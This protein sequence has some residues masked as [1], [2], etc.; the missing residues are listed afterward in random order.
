MQREEQNNNVRQWEAVTWIGN[1]RR[2]EKGG[3]IRYGGTQEKIP[4]GQGHEQ[5]YILMWGGKRGDNWKV[6][7]TR[8]VG[9]SQDPLE[10]K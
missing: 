1:Q 2:K 8:D 7:N 3:R 6:P 5:K 10:M 9:G 4:E